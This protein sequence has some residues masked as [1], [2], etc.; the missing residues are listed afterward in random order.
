[1]SKKDEWTHETSER[2][3]SLFEKLQHNRQQVPLEVLQAK[4]AEPY[5][6]LVL[7]LTSWLAS[8][9]SATLTAFHP[10]APQRHGG[11]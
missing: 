3:D 4:Y 11:E 8:S 5:K 10:H 9:Q 6:R 2:F 1:M 7:E